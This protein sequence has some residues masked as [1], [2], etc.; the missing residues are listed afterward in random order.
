MKPQE[1]SGT[2]RASSKQASFSASSA[3][4]EDHY[5]MA[6]VLAWSIHVRIALLNS[7]GCGN[8]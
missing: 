1:K 6:D 5:E 7:R 4:C 3:F 8:E 2:A